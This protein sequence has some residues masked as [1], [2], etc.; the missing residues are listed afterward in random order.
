[1]SGKK[2]RKKKKF[3]IFQG[4][5]LRDME[6]RN[7]DFFLCFSIYADDRYDA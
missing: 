6:T 4:H 1:M 7:V 3:G 2:E 5:F